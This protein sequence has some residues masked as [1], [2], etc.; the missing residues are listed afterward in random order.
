MGIPVKFSLINQ[1]SAK[2]A[3]AIIFAFLYFHFAALR[4]LFFIEKSAVKAPT[5]FMAV[6]RSGLERPGFEHKLRTWI[7]ARERRTSIAAVLNLV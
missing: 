1:T 6:I 3:S 4:W 7:V 5:A 2:V